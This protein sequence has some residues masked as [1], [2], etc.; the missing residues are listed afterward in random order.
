MKEKRYIPTEFAEKVYKIL[1]KVPKGKITTYKQLAIA[2]GS[3]SCARAI[4]N[5]LH[6]NPYA[7]I[8]PCHRVVKSDGKLGGFASG[9]ENKKKLLEEEGIEISND[10]SV[11]LKKYEFRF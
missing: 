6:I 7:P 11:N 4:G 5:V 1:K 2:V 8:V 10:F 3:P 9:C